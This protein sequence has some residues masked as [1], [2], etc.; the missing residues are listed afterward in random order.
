MNA[1]QNIL[2]AGVSLMVASAC[3]QASLPKVSY[4]ATQ[5]GDV[6][7]DYFGTKVPD[8]YRWMEDLDSKP[9]A[10]WIAAENKVTFDYLAKLPMREHFKR[11]IT[12]LWDY[13]KVSIPVREGG[14]YF[15]SKNSGLQ[16][17]API[18]MR[19]SLTEPPTLVLDPNVLS[20]DGSV[21][22]GQWTP[23][24]DGRLLAYGLS[25]G[26]ADWRTLH[27]RDIDS[28]KDL[29]DE[30]RWM[31]FS[32]ISWTNDGK[33]FFYSRYPEPPKG[34]A[35]EAALVRPGHLLP[36]CRHAPIPGPADL[37]A[38]GSAH[39][40]RGWHG[41]RRR[42]LSDRHHPERIGQQQSALLCRP[43]RP[44]AAERLARPSSP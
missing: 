25:E 10:D 6:V 37:R 44:H 18:Y 7:E 19:S 9:V 14:R 31:R 11:R 2:A 26:G 3:R 13:P 16:R 8:P 38:Q 15:Y 24:R 43:G 32:G 27:V 42:A 34:K 22:L 5:K 23:S 4:P 30:V 28:G 17:Q 35:L 20:P 1:K 40:V 12:E 36:P 41:H 21:S 39:M 29:P 33:G